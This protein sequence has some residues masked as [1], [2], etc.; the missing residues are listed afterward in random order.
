MR[1]CYLCK[2]IKNLEDFYKDKSQI[3]GFDFKCKK[4]ASES[5]KLRR[6]KNPEYYKKKQKINLEKNYDKIRDCQKKYKQDNLEKINARRREL[7][8]KRKIYLNEKEKIRR[9]NDPL[10]NYKQR[11]SQKKWRDAKKI[12]LKPQ[13]DA[14]KLVFFA[15]KL[16]LIVKPE[17]CSECGVKT[18]LEGH[19]EDYKKP[20][21]VVWLCKLCH[22]QRH[23]KYEIP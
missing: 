12:K 6:K 23:R 15:I 17:N 2:E 11:I 18:K 14:H 3:S 21:D 20:L 5:A 7:R 22:Q 9:K 1:K 16:G 19:H 13:T 8:E 4:C 10:F